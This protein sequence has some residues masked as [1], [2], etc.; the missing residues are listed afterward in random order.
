MMQCAL[1]QLNS[2][3]AGLRKRATNCLSSLAPHVNDEMLGSAV[4]AVVQLLKKKQGIKAEMTRTYIQMVGALCR[5]V[6]YRFGPHLPETLPLLAAYCRE[7]SENDDEI[8]E[9]SLQALESFVLRCPRDV[10]LYC[11]AIL[12]LS[13]DYLSYDPNFTDAMDADD[14][15]GGG[16]DDDEEADDEEEDYSDDEDMSWKVRR[17]AAKCLSA[18]INTRPEMLA[19]L[20]A[21]ASPKL[22]ERFT[23]R[24]ENVKI[25][26]FNAYNDLLR[27]TGHASKSVPDTSVG[28]PAAMLQQELGKLVKSLKQ[29]L[30]EKSVKTRV[31]AFSVLKELVIVLPP[32]SLESHCASLVPGIEKALNDKASNL[33]IEALGYTRLL[34]ASHPPHVFQPHIKTLMGPVLAAVAE[35]YYKLAA[36]AVRVCGEIVKAIR[37][38]QASPSSFD[39]LP[40]I[41]PLYSAILKRLTAQDQDQ[42]VKECAIWCMGLIVSILGDHLRAEMRTCLPLLLDRLRNE[43]TRLTTVK[44]FGTISESPLHIDL[45]SINGG[46]VPMQLAGV[47][48]SSLLTQV[49]MELTSFLRKANRPLRQASLASFNSLL[50]AY[51]DK[52]SPSTYEAITAELPSLITDSD[53]ALTALALELCCT[54]MGDKKAYA[55]AGATFR[56]RILPQALLLVRSPLL[57]GQALLTLQR[58][59]ESLLRSTTASFDSLLEALLATAKGGEKGGNGAVAASSS[60][61]MAIGGAVGMSK[62]AYY[63]VAQCVAVLCVVAGDA[64]CIATVS[65]LIANLKG[66]TGADATQ[67][68]SLLCLGEIG[69]RKD[70]GELFNLAS[71]VTACFQSPSDEIKSAASYALGSIAAGNHAKY[72][73]FILSQINSQDKLQYLLLHSLK[74]VISQPSGNESKVARIEDL[75]PADMEAVL[76]LLFVHSE[77][78]EEGVRNVVAECLGK[79]SMMEPEKLVPALLQRLS[80]PSAFTR[81]TMVMALKFTIA[82]EPQRVDEFIKPNM[83]SFLLLQDDDRHVRRA[84][85]VALSTAAHNK[86]SLLGDLLPS[87]LPLLYDQMTIKQEMIRTVDLGPFKHTVDDGL[88]LRKAAFDCLD[89]LLTSCL[90]RIDPSSFITPYLLSGL[91]DDYDVKMPCHLILSKLAERCGHAVLAVIDALIEPLSKTVTAKVKSDAVKQEVDRNEDMI[92]S[93]LRAIHSLTRI[94]NVETSAR[95]KHFMNSCVKLGTIGQL[96]T[97]VRQEQHDTLT[98][99]ALPHDTGAAMDTS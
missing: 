33:K 47:S 70:L 3:R 65:R 48:D 94:S 18:V 39:F 43:I 36:E 90:D 6:G 61:S 53:L 8:R 76:G 63:S 10:A 26:V 56:D 55:S 1:A 89:T 2:T 74:E 88:E 77:S 75:K 15:G 86:P 54:M 78:P 68:L 58:F 5:S 4:A 99:L 17:A 23:E 46:P 59:F 25:D 84:A 85:V 38:Q 7:A 73:P 13:L 30:R 29:Q 40:Y 24:E 21:K 11:P 51:S 37:P 31:G 34:M 93:A 96:Y 44:A 67:L 66:T 20:Y 28:S 97:Q 42:E 9:N 69:R 87:L 27:Q 35:R 80:S 72:L 50:Q 71:Q 91:G 83:A 98:G 41:P 32:G 57:Q 45:F 49:L 64:K 92:R 12:D 79:L 22:I 52:I 16:D 81:A 14:E 60:T 95:F 62:Q 82:D 19:A